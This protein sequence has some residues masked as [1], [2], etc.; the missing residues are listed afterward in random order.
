MR[1]LREEV[2]LLSLGSSVAG[3]RGEEDDGSALRRQGLSIAGRCLGDY[4]G[5]VR[6][7]VLVS[8]CLFG[9]QF[10]FCILVFLF[11]LASCL[12]PHVVGLFCSAI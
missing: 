7:R 6:V 9:L 10:W 4:I 12:I 5:W 1:S 11:Y 2:G 3:V 8:M